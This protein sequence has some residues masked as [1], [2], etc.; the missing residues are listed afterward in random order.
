[1]PVRQ[2]SIAV[3]NE[4]GKLHE[5]CNL[6]EKEQINIKGIMAAA[7]LTPVQLHLVVDD[8]E[9]AIA[10]LDSAGFTTATKEV[11]AVAAPDH[12]GGLNAVMRTLLDGNINVETLY[13]FI[14]LDGNEAILIMEVDDVLKAKAILKTHWIQTFGAE[15]YRT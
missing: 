4:P 6:M 8:P 14:R 9:R 12:P 7:K 15:I 11:L 13:P 2:I 10:I 5:I 3:D 1:M